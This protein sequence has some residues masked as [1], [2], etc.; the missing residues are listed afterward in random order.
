MAGWRRTGQGA[1]RGWRFRTWTGGWCHWVWRMRRRVRWT[2]RGWPGRWGVWN[3]HLEVQNADR[4]SW[5][6]G[7]HKY[8]RMNNHYK[9][10]PQKDCKDRD[11]TRNVRG[12]SSWGYRSEF[13]RCGRIVVIYSISS[14]KSVVVGSNSVS[15][16]DRGCE[17]CFI[18]SMQ[19]RPGFL[20]RWVVL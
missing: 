16:N 15:N 9:K 20:P 12:T 6:I 8:C 1:L 14:R 3:S 2:W 13:P 11:E 10:Q 7:S 18:C 5:H 17:S 19:K 4:C